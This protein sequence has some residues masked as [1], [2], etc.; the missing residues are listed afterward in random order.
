MLSL[1]GVVYDLRA[2]SDL[3]CVVSAFLALFLAPVFP[4]LIFDQDLTSVFVSPVSFSCVRIIPRS[5]FGEC[6]ANRELS[7]LKGEGV[8]LGRDVGD[9]RQHEKLLR[10]AGIMHNH[11][12]KE[13]IGCVSCEKKTCSIAK[14]LFN[15]HVAQQHVD[16]PHL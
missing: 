5:Q 14:T 12:A 9:A 15:I 3:F 8:K 11:A 16:G 4:C 7:T 6:R 1:R 10:Q 2:Y 13:N